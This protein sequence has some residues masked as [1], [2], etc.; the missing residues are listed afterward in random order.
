[1]LKKSASLLLIA[2]MLF[3]CKGYQSKQDNTE[4]TQ[5]IGQEVMLVE[6]LNQ[7]AETL[8]GETVTV[9]GTVVHVCQHGGK[10]M[11]LIG[12][13]PEIRLK[14]NAG[15][16]IASFDREKEGS[17]V[18]VIGIVE[19]FRIDEAYLSQ[20]EE[21]LEAE[22][23]EGGEE[24]EH[25]EGEHGDGEHGDGEHMGEHTGMGD[26]AD[27]GE[28]ISSRE[29]IKNYREEIAASD[30]DFIAFYSILASEYQEIPEK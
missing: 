17:L 28:H 26:K 24:K 21:E 14:I 16:E 18:R 6:E 3:G 30:K 15:D 9:E 19:E 4:E 22:E 12:E 5:S 1:M 29:M 25:I 23:A 10:K 2:F 8:V 27:Q 7:Q 20:W 13:D 11:F